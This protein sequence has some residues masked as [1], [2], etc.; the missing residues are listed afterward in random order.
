MTALE[1]RLPK[2]A[3]AAAVEYARKLSDLAIQVVADT[4]KTIGAAEE[5]EVEVEK[6]EVGRR[7][8]EIQGEL[9][10]FL[11]VLRLPVLDARVSHQLAD[12]R[13]DLLAVFAHPDDIVATFTLD[14]MKVAEWRQPR[15]VGEF[16]TNVELPVGVK[17]GWFSKS[18]QQESAVIDDS[19]IGSFTHEAQRLELRLRRKVTDRD[20]LEIVLERDG[21]QVTATVQHLDAPEAEGQQTPLDAAAIENLQRLWDGLTQSLGAALMER[22]SLQSVEF[23]GADVVA[24]DHGRDFIRQVVAQMAP[25]V[26]EIARR[27][28]NSG[29]LTLKLE[30]EG[31]RREEIY[32]RKIDL[33]SKLDA[34]PPELRE[35][36]S[37]LGLDGDPTR[38]SSPQLETGELADAELTPTIEPE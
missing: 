26:M 18:V 19:F 37:P 2:D 9:Q 25:V 30:K 7:R 20:T 34:L 29:E 27:T 4:K 15:R 36:F 8:A 28:P 17:R 11:T 31:G 12:N 16:A 24:L 21:D 5:H 32:V 33:A 22:K 14:A 13:N 35:V 38:T 3:R 6:R 10:A 1:E 23:R